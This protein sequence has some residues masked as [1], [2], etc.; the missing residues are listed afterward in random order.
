MSIIP[1]TSQSMAIKPI[2]HMELEN[3][4]RDFQNKLGND[5]DKYQE[6]LSLFLIGK[7]SRNE[8]VDTITP[9]LKDGLVKY[10]NKLLLMNFA[11]SLKEGPLDS[12]T[13]FAS[14]WNKK[15]SKTK[16]VKS[17]QYEKFKM[18]IMGLPIRERRRIK[19]ISRESGK[20][21]KLSA[22]ITLTRH[23]LLPKIPMIQDK[24]QQQSHV[25]NLVQWQQDVV[26]GINT[27]IATENYEIP[28]YDNLSRRMIMT[29]REHGLTGGLNPQVMEVL[30]LGL[31]VHLKNIIESAIDVARYRENK[32]ASNDYLSPSSDLGTRIENR[33]D[34]ISQERKRQK[35]TLGAEDL[36]DTLEMFPHL[37]EPGG[38]KLRLANVMLQNDDMSTTGELDYELPPKSE[39]INGTSS[40][41]TLLVNQKGN[42]KDELTNSNNGHPIVPKDEEDAGES[43]DPKLD[44]QHKNSLV[45]HKQAPTTAQISKQIPDSHTGTN[46][47]LKWLLHDLISTM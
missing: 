43:V 25:N 18:N 37:I 19:N 30:L 41:D 3:H 21:G 29:M 27:P 28:D 35:V 6:A 4:I 7:L 14:F 22:S 8:M 36:Y 11:N 46:D 47:D 10:H 9:L 40:N 24:A 15:A 39:L 31:E 1:A 33:E 17:S 2:D 32:Y 44:T 16:N 38:P 12:Q 42:D 34:E 5:W 45:P 23:A 26:N 13:E 20:K